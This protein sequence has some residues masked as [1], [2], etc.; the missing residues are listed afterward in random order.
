MAT[1]KQTPKSERSIAVNN[2]RDANKETKTLSGTI[3]IVQK[4]WADGYKKAFNY[5]GINH[6]DLNLETIKNRCQKNTDGLIYLTS[7]KAQKNEAGEFIKGEN[8]KRVYNSVDAVVNVWS[9][10]KLFKVLEQSINK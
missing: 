4:F 8:G 6:Y 3:K 2:L 1:K 7:K 10:T 5:V 9:V